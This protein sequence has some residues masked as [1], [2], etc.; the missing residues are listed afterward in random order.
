MSAADL[1]GAERA[2]QDVFA[3]G[4]VTSASLGFGYRRL[5][6]S[7]ADAADGGKRVRPALFLVA[8]R[9]WGGTDARSADGVAA[10]L[11]LLHTAFVVHDDVI[12]GDHT[13]RGRFNVSGAHAAQ[14]H[15]AGVDVQRS[16]EY[17][18]AA[19]IL[20]GDLALAAA[21]RAV[22]FCPADR[23]TVL[24]L[25]DLFDSALHT[26]AAGELADVWM[27]L[28]VD[29]PGVQESLSV[30]ERKTGAYSFTLP[31]QAA[32]VLAGAPEAAVASS[33]DVGR[34]LGI[35]FQLADDLLGVFGDPATTGKSTVSDLRAGKQT[36]LVAHARGTSRWPEIA[37]FVGRADLTEDQAV[38]VRRLLE[39]SG[40]RRFVEELAG[41]YA[42]GALACG[43]D[44][45]LPTE[46]VSFVR[47]LTTDLPGR[48]S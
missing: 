28:G 36:P 37:P 31:L 43:C 24:R 22:A 1:V 45:G 46:L 38:H 7:L 48:T 4:S 21:L 16:S 34:F 40:S 26:T 15:A 39:A 11:E 23:A 2:L 47:A 42:R 10:A 25:F 5:W 30:E 6:G 8:Y 35:A 41:D 17:G 19:G 32:A 3:D 44:A 12:D 14:A 29:R 33:G 9:A 13:R 27:S 20:A 18:V